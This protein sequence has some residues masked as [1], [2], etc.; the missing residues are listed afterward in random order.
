MLI[1]PLVTRLNFCLLT[2]FPL[3]LA[4]VKMECNK[5]NKISLYYGLISYISKL[6]EMGKQE[7]GEWGQIEIICMGF[8]TQSYK[9]AVPKSSA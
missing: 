5:S 4:I 2:S 9:P 8:Y 1:I 7:E 3:S 6:L